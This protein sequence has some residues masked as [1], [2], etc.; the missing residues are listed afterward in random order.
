MNRE[1]TPEIQALRAFQRA[2][3]K[4]RQG[5]SITDEELTILIARYKAAYEAMN[6]VTH[7]TY[8]LVAVDL[9]RRYWQLVSFQ[10]ARDEHRKPRFQG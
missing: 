1:D 7:P 6:A 9:S 5:D 3:A 4:F 8:N 2:D 10:K